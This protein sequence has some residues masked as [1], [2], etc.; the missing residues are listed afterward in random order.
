[1]SEITSGMRSVLSNPW[2]YNLLQNLLGGASARKEIVARYIRP[3]AG[4]HLL[5]IGCGPA[6]IL[7]L[8]PTDIQYTGFDA[9]AQYIDQARRRFG[10]RGKFYQEYVSD[11][12]L[13]DIDRFDLVLAGGILHHLQDDEVFQLSQ[14]AYE[15]L[16]ANGRF[17]TIDPAIESGQ[18]RLAR[19]LIQR[20]RGQNVRSAD[21]YRKLLA[22][23]QAWSA[24]RVDIRHDLLFFPYTHAIIECVK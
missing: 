7:S 19:F 6:D 18:S 22:E 20:D 21:G 2:I 11:A 24:V 13:Q 10:D 8:L 4:Q 3:Q 16:K 9:S 1:M 23:R 17:L 15:A 14:L 5:D 12:A